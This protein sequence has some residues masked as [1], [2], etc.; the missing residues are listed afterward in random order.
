MD[1]FRPP[2]KKRQNIVLSRKCINCIFDP[3]AEKPQKSDRGGKRINR[4]F[5]PL[6]EMPRKTDCVGL[7]W[8]FGPFRKNAE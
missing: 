7:D 4:I 2:P 6:P 3:L 5:D 1:F 8:V